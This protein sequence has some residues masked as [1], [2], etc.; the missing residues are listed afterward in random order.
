[1]AII[2]ATWSMSLDEETLIKEMLA[3]GEYGLGA[4]PITD[5]SLMEFFRNWAFGLDPLTYRDEW[6]RNP[7]CYYHLEVSENYAGKQLWVASYFPDNATDT[8]KEAVQS[9]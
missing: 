4:H 7:L 1:M 9:L 5:E 8:M 3:T 6:A 2:T